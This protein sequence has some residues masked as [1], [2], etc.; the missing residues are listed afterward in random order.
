MTTDSFTTTAGVVVHCRPINDKLRRKALAVIEKAY[1]D[2][3]EPIDPPT[4]TVHLVGGD[5]HMPHDETTLVVDGDEAQTQANQVAWKKYLEA[6]GRLGAEQRDK[7]NAIQLLDGLDFE[8]PTDGGWIERQKR[9]YGVEVPT[10]PDEQRLHYIETELL[11]TASDLMDAVQTITTLSL[12]GTVE[13]EAVREE[14]ASFRRKV[15]GDATRAMS[16]VA[17]ELESLPEAGG[18]SHGEGMGPALPQPVART[19]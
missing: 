9:R 5:E 1:R 11:I 8:M 2:R 13:E 16:S 15:Q 18:D 17:R 10:D 6:R 14:M 7:S 3:G 4:Y 19:E 12:A